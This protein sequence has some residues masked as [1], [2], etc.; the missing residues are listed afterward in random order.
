MT[1]NIFK[2]SEY[3]RELCRP[4]GK[5]SILKLLQCSA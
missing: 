3:W 4:K 1:L 5:K 2:T